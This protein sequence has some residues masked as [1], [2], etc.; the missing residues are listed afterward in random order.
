MDM[1]EGMAPCGG[2]GRWPKKRPSEVA[3]PRDADAALPANL[4]ETN[5]THRKVIEIGNEINREIVRLQEAVV[6]A[7]LPKGKQSHGDENANIGGLAG[8]VSLKSR[9]TAV[10]Y[11]GVFNTAARAK[12]DDMDTIRVFKANESAP[13]VT[14]CFAHGIQV[15]AKSRKAAIHNGRTAGK[16][17]PESAASAHGW[18]SHCV[19][20]MKSQD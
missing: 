4:R 15:A 2:R 20:A 6:K 3:N 11:V 16:A 12:H 8:C 5:E 18:C 13:Y 17:A 19:K 14:H 1:R 9:D 7:R 10:H